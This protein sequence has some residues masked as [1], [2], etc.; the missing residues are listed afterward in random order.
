MKLYVLLKDIVLLN[1]VWNKPDCDQNIIP[2]IFF[3]KKK[4][5]SPKRAF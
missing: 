4:H 5:K 1:I 2:Y 3:V